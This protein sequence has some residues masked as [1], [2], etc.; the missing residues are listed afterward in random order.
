MAVQCSLLLLAH[1]I[2]HQKTVMP[3]EVGIDVVVGLPL[4]PLGLERATVRNDALRAG[5]RRKDLLTPAL[6]YVLL[7]DLGKFLACRL[8]LLNKAFVPANQEREQPVF[9]HALGLMLLAGLCLHFSS[10]LTP[11][12]RAKCVNSNHALGYHAL[13]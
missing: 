12:S 8:A 6:D 2:N 10:P 7:E 3:L 13:E 4:E 5:P 11:V 9:L 1:A